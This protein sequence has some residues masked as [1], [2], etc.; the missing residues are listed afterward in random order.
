MYCVH[1]ISSTS[2]LLKAVRSTYRLSFHLN[3]KHTLI[4]KKSCVDNSICKY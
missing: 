2:A 3:F 1:L 4:F